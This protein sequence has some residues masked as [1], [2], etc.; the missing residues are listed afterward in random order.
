MMTSVTKNNDETRF[1]NDDLP[2][3]TSKARLSHVM[4]KVPSVDQVV[5]YWTK[6]Y[7]EFVVRSSSQQTK[8]DDDKSKQSPALKSAFVAL[9]NGSNND[10]TS[11]FTLELVGKNINTPTNDPEKHHHHQLGNIISYI[12]V[13][14]NCCCLPP[15]D[16]EGMKQQD[17]NGISVKLVASPSGGDKFCQFCFQTKDLLDTQSF[18]E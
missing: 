13:S 1:H 8:D 15:Q 11:F 17:P 9:G 14:S 3:S 2:M 18:W 12:G 16:D 10:D 4:L 5:S 6:Y 7:G